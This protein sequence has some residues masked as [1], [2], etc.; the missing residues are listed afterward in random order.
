MSCLTRTPLTED[1]ITLAGT[2]QDL[3][4]LISVALVVAAAVL[5]LP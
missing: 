1:P 5:A 3:C 2:V 4:G